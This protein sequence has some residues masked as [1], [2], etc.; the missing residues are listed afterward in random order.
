MGTSENG[1]NYFCI[2]L[3]LSFIK[4]IILLRVNATE[5]KNIVIFDY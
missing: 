3:S 2:G 4:R 1:F 5:P